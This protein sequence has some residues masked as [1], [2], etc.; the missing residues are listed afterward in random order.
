MADQYIR[1]Y[2]GYYND[3]SVLNTVS[4]GGAATILSELMIEGGGCVLGVIYSSDFHSAIYSCAKRK[5]ELEAFKGSKYI[6]PEN[7]CMMDGKKIDII[8]AVEML[9]SDEKRILLIGTGCRIASIKKILFLKGVAD[10]NLFT[11]DLIC[12]GPTYPEVQRDYIKFLERKYGAKIIDF[13]VRYKKRGWTPPYMRAVF[14]NG[15]I[16]EFPF[17]ETDYGYALQNHALLSCY[18]CRIKGDQHPSDITVGDYWGITEE[19]DGYNPYGVSI[20]VTHTQKGED[21]INGI[22][23]N[24]FCIRTADFNKVSQ[25]NK[26]YFECRDMVKGYESFKCNLRENG[27]HNAVVKD[28]G[29]GLYYLKSLVRHA[30]EWKRRFSDITM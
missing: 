18:R 15:R 3:K 2:S 8:Q 27:L 10:D 14:S 19:M 21:M 16:F 12:H 7:K 6:M 1:V 22:D 4:S 5:E 28:M 29:T 13:S 25:Y 17:Y 11:I 24:K 9:L 30:R 20:L 23:K 26:P